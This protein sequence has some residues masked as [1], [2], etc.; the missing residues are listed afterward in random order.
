MSEQNFGAQQTQR[1]HD[2]SVTSPADAAQST[3]STAREA[4]AQAAD[5][6]R[7]AGSRAREAASET[8]STLTD[9]VHDLLDRQVRQGAAMAGHVARSARIA[10]DELQREAPLLAGLMRSGAGRLDGVA[11]AI[12][13]KGIHDLTR[14][15]ADF[16]RRQPALV[17]GAARASSFYAP[18]ATPTPRRPGG[19]AHLETAHHERSPRPPA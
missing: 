10:A 16:T 2:D 11:G 19:R 12:E 14:T 15:A 17:F 3:R 4:F 13:G 18:S 6:A 1:T 7:D 5:M 9:H 8:A